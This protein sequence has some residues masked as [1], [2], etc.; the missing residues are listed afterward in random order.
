MNV[1]SRATVYVLADDLA[2]LNNPFIAQHGASYWLSLDYGE[3][4][5]N[6]LFD[7]GTYPGPIVEN[8]TRLGLDPRAIDYVILSHNHYD[9]TGG[10]LGVLER[11]NH[12]VPVIAP[13]SL[14]RT[15]IHLGGKLRIINAPYYPAKF[16]DEIIARNGYPLLIDEPVKIADGVWTTGVFDQC[17]ENNKVFFVD[18]GRLIP[19]TLC[20]EIALVIDLGEHG[21]VVTG[22]A[23]PG[24]DRIVEKASTIIGKRIRYVLGGLH[25]VGLEESRVREIAEKL[26]SHGVER[27]YPGHCTGLGAEYILEKIYG[28][29]CRVLRAGLKIEFHS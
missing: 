28:E 11:I 18:N 22:C 26:M 9:H 16:L 14:A 4:K 13:S 10:L 6:I 17:G 1:P 20:D 19:D 8:M 12:V 24:I 7:T 2:G 5:I 25:M 23:H 21:L 3:K 27:V 15:S 29:N